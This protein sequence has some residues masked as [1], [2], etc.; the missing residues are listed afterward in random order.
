[1][2]LDYVL[3]LGRKPL[4]VLRLLLSSLSL[5]LRPSL[6]LVYSCVRR[7]H[8]ALKL[9]KS[10]ISKVQ[11]PLQKHIFQKWQKKNFFCTRK[12]SENC[13]FGSFKLYSCAKLDFFAIF[14]IS[15]LCFC[16]FEIAFFPQF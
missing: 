6:A 12:K 3:A 13:I 9:E 8:S 10:A 2:R 15:K 11:K 1:M 5:S 4:V 7:P 16:T 14:Q